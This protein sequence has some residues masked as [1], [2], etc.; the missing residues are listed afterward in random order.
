MSENALSCLF[1]SIRVVPAFD[2]WAVMGMWKDEV[3]LL[4][5]HLKVLYF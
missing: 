4:I 5:K 3:G 2:N 1:Y